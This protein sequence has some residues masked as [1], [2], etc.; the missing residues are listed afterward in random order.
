LASSSLFSSSPIPIASS[1][2]STRLLARTANGDLSAG[3][4]PLSLSGTDPTS[5]DS[6]LVHRA[7]GRRK[8]GGDP[9]EEILL[10][11]ELQASGAVQ[12]CDGLRGSGGGQLQRRACGSSRSG[13]SELDAN[14][15]CRQPPPAHPRSHRQHSHPP[16]PVLPPLVAPTRPVASWCRSSATAAPWWRGRR[17]AGRD[18][19]EAAALAPP[20]P[21]AS[22]PSIRI[23]LASPP[24]CYSI[25][26]PQLRLARFF[27]PLG[28][29]GA[30]CRCR[31]KWLFLQILL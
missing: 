19:E 14:L 25:H 1:A 5:R 29:E 8:A 11:G 28:R 2:T 27:P 3:D 4:L 24:T 12:A 9:V 18:D 21:P 16:P 23:Y 13:S 20:P 15:G 10:R 17:G 30:N 6:F 22:S 31:W 26:A 7:R